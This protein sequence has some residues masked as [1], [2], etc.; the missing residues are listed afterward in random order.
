ME[1]IAIAVLFAFGVHLLILWIRHM[2][3]DSHY[4][5]NI[6]IHG[7]CV[8]GNE[9]A[10]NDG[11]IVWVNSDETETIFYGSPRHPVTSSF[12][13]I[14]IRLYDVRNRVYFECM[15]KDQ[16]VI[17]RATGGSTA[18]IQIPDRRVSHKHCRIYRQGE[19][20]LIQDL[21]STNH[22]YLDGC[23]ISG[24]VPILSGAMLTVGANTYRFECTH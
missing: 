4:N 16:L 11:D 14:R 23:R 17:G 18:D 3:A 24:V 6:S 20:V 10:A 2:R 19:Q 9:R 1:W 13:E 5:Q 8:V 7:G 12:P 22:T 21:E 15:L